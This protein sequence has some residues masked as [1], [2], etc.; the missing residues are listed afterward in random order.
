MIWGSGFRALGLR[1]KNLGLRFETSGFVVQ[2]FQSR[3]PQTFRI[4][5]PE[6]PEPLIPNP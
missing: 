1:L 6:T 2:G 4:P 3:L 5:G